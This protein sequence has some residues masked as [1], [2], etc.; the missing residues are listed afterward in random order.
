LQKWIRAE[1]RFTDRTS[2]ARSADQLK[3]KRRQP[4]G[5]ASR[6]S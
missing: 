6:A 3:D 2:G 1:C 4:F 5:R